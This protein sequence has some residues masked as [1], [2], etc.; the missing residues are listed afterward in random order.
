MCVARSFA[1]AA[2]VLVGH[3]IHLAYYACMHAAFL[4]TLARFSP[5]FFCAARAAQRKIAG[6]RFYSALFA[7]RFMA[8]R[9]GNSLI[10]TLMQ[11][12]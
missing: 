11:L 4:C 9:H 1:A 8:L 12:I 2:A 3:K 7:P 10:A 5:A 6:A